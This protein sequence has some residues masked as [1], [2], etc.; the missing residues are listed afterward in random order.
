MFLGPQDLSILAL[1]FGVPIL[2]NL[3]QKA[4]QPEEDS[5]KQTQN[6][7][8]SYLKPLFQAVKQSFSSP[9]L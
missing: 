7:L 1:R 5:I 2:S 9:A 4:K 3:N 8:Q 6:F